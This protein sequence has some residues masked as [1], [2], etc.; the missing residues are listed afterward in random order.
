MGDSKAYIRNSDEK[1][2]INIS[3][4]VIAVI[5]AAATMEVEGV[6]SLFFSYGK[7]PAK[8]LSKKALSRGIKLHIDGDVVTIDVYLIASIGYCVNE[9]GA[10][11]QRAVATAVEATVGITVNAVNVHVCGVSLKKNK[12]NT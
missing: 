7:E 11:V 5:T 3:E 8:A 9:I 10:D 12:Q 2:S 1:G 4:E 6:H